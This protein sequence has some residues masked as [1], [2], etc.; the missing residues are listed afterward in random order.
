MKKKTFWLA[1]IAMMAALICLCSACSS[2]GTTEAEATEVPEETEIPSVTAPPAEESEDDMVAADDNSAPELVDSDDWLASLSEEQRMVEEELIG[3]TVDE[4][5]E[6]LGEPRTA[7]YS[8]S[9][10]VADAQDGLLYYDGFYVS[11]TL[12]PN[13]TEYVMGTGN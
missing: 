2:S 10:L 1:A 13:G 5:Y 9:C 3:V 4:L 7:V 11:T 6:V 8:T 12:F